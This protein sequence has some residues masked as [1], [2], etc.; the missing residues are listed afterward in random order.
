LEHHDSS[1]THPLQS[2]I[3]SSEAGDK[4]A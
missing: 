3:V 4:H 2:R 1:V